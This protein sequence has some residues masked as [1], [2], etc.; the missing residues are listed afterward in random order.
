MGFVSWPYQELKNI[1]NWAEEQLS[2]QCTNLKQQKED[3]ITF[4]SQRQAATGSHIDSVV[5]EV[6]KL[7]NGFKASTKLDW[8]RHSSSV[9]SDFDK[10]IT[11]FDDF[12]VKI[13]NHIEESNGV[14]QTWAADVNTSLETARHENSARFGTL[15]DTVITHGS[16]VDGVTCKLACNTKKA[17]TEL[18][19]IAAQLD[20]NVTEIAVNMQQFPKAIDECQADMNAMRET[21]NRTI[22]KSSKVVAAFQ[23]ISLPTTVIRTL[24]ISNGFRFFDFQDFNQQNTFNAHTTEGEIFR[25]KKLSTEMQASSKECV[26]LLATS[27]ADFVRDVTSIVPP[28]GQTPQKRTYFAPDSFTCTRQTDIIMNEVRQTLQQ[29]QKKKKETKKTVVQPSILDDRTTITTDVEN[30]ILKHAADNNKSSSIQKKNDGRTNE[31]RVIE[32][33]AAQDP[34]TR[35]Q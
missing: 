21:M 24:L 18:D 13:A 31:S 22:V 33:L 14:A 30:I 3:I 25:A 16:S 19:T 29:Q 8:E 27:S 11:M 6:N 35:Q 10:S 12:G 15:R 28:S 4:A 32:P 2:L 1:Q 34:N 20:S 17:R 5:A 7:M 23:L 9:L 26:Q